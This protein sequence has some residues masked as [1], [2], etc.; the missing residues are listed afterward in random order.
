MPS[1]NLTADNWRFLKARLVKRCLL[2]FSFSSTVL[3][4]CIPD[5]STINGVLTV[6]SR[7][8]VEDGTGRIRNIVELREAA[9][10]VHISVLFR[11]IL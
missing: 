5:F 8:Q 4:R 3:Q 2:W 6:G 10:Y 9:A 7:M 1:K 11:C